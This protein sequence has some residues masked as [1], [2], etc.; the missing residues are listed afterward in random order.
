[1]LNTATNKA[2]LYVDDSLCQVC[3]G[4]LAQQVCKVRAIV[5]ID[6]DEAPMIDVHRCHGCLACQLEC[7]FNAIVTV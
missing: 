4:C 1:M 6:R 3:R 2:T 5:R 7:P